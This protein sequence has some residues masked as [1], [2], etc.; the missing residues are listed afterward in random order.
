MKRARSGENVLPPVA[1]TKIIRLSGMKIRLIK[2]DAP[3]L[4]LRVPMD[5]LQTGV[6]SFLD[7]RD[8]ISFAR[9]SRSWYHKVANEACKKFAAFLHRESANLSLKGYL[10]EVKDTLESL[11][12]MAIACYLD[13]GRVEWDKNF[14]LRRRIAKPWD[15]QRV[16]KEFLAMLKRSMG[17]GSI[18]ALK[19]HKKHMASGLGERFEAKAKE[20]ERI[21]AIFVEMLRKEGYETSLQLRILWETRGIRI[22]A[23][24]LPPFPAIEASER[25]VLSNLMTS[26]A[27]LA[28][29]TVR[30]LH[31]PS[32][33]SALVGSKMAWKA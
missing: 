1:S 11:T 20:R 24:V 23:N 7:F 2:P 27:G 6:L 25:F 33:I 28:E 19:T 13:I 18:D 8:T 26:L 17:H 3:N 22:D 12:P 21:F 9:S 16:M 5:V 15:S 10:M 4:F 30:K 29:S 32:V 14:K 31:M